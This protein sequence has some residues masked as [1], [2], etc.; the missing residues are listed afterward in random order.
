VK[1]PGELFKKG[2]G[3]RRKSSRSTRRPEVLLGIKQLGEDP[4]AGIEKR[5]KKGDLVTGKVTRVPTSAPSWRSPTGSRGLC[6][7]P[8]SPGR[9]SRAPR[10]RSAG[11][12]G[13]GGGPG[14][15]RVNKKVS[16]SMRGYLD[17]LER[18]NTESYI[19]KQPDP[20]AENV[21][22]WR[23]APRQAQARQRGEGRLTGHGGRVLSTAAPP[24]TVRPGVPHVT[25]VLVAFFALLGSSR[26]WTATPCGRGTRSRL[27]PL[28]G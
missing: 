19:G 1:N 27:S 11:G 28:P 14:V 13:G 21:G 26:A 18:K 4:W 8:R 10:R 7:S 3:S 5:F 22:P 15:D 25:L 17:E 24:A 12:H 20:P 16:L 23:G 2:T 6:T 9:R